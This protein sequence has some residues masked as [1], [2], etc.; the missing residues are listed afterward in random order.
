MSFP[1]KVWNL[2]Y[3]RLRL[4]WGGPK[5]YVLRRWLLD[6]GWYGFTGYVRIIG[7]LIQVYDKR[8]IVEKSDEP[9]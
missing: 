9:A 6:A 4:A 8:S 3:W 5:D 1:W 7:L 2:I